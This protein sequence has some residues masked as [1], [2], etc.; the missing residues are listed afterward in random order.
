MDIVT[1]NIQCGKGCDGIVDLRRIVETACALAPADVLC[2]QEVAVNFPELDGGS[3]EDQVAVLAALLPGYQAIFRPGVDR[4]G[5]ETGDRRFGNA[6]FSRL[7]VLQVLAHLLPRPAEAG[8]RSMQRLALEVVV[9]APFGPLRIV[10]T[11]LEYHSVAHRAAQ[12]EFLRDVHREAAMRARLKDAPDRSQGPYRSIARP[13]AA[14]LCGDF[15]F[16]PADPLHARIQAPFE[17]DV[18]A[19]LDAW[20]FLHPKLP[21]PPTCG[22]A[23]FAQWPSGPHCRDFAFVT[24]EIASRA[25]RIAV[26]GK[27]TA[28]DHQP[29]LLTLA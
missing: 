13:A 1:W 23:D 22:I 27:T 28:S 18:P 15:N 8:G 2:F 24:A 16:E 3:G 26:D 9:D 4:P 12:V 25:R 20:T 17:G 7:P 29:L 6:L 21:H 11:H 19:F 5:T 10:T 14:V